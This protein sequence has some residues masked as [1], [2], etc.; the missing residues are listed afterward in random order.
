MITTS[1]IKREFASIFVPQENDGTIGTNFHA[2]YFHKS[3]EESSFAAFEKYG[4]GI[5]S[6][7]LYKMGYKGGGIGVHQQGIK[8]PRRDLSMKAWVMLHQK[9]GL[10][11]T[12]IVYHVPSVT[13]EDMRRQG[14]GLCI[15]N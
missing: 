9:N 15:S 7:L 5:G 1:K 8:N 6:K 14:V 10:L 3:V 11:M 13:K 2:S 12:T 4:N